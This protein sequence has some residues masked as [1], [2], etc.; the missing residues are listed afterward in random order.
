MVDLK[1]EN[2]EGIIQ[3][4][5]SVEMYKANDVYEEI[6]EMYLT[7]KNIICYYEKSN[8]LFA[9]SEE[10]IEKIPLQSIRIVNDK[11][12]ISKVDN[13][14]YGLGLQI[15]LQNGERAHFVFDKKKELQIWYDAILE[16]ITGKKNEG[17]NL[18]DNSKEKKN[19]IVNSFLGVVGTVKDIAKDQ[20]DEVKDQIDFVKDI[21]VDDESN[22]FS[23][24]NNKKRQREKEIDNENK[25]IDNNPNE[26]IEEKN[27]KE[28]SMY[29]SNCGKEINSNS[30]FCNCCGASVNIKENALEEKKEEIR[31]EVE[32]EELSERKI[33]YDGKIHKCPN[34]GDV[35]R[36]FDIVCP[37]CGFEL[38]G[39]EVSKTLQ[40]FIE[41]VNECEQTISNSPKISNGGWS[42]WSSGKKFGFIILNLIFAF[43]PLFIYFLL[44]FIKIKTKPNL[45]KEEQQ[46]ES[47]IENFPFPNDRESIIDALIFAKEKMDFISKEEMNRKNAYWFRLWSS[48]AEQLKHK[49]D[50]LF[51]NDKIVNESYD[52]ILNKNAEV[53][54]KLKIKALIGLILLIVAIVFL[55]MRS[56][57]FERMDIVDTTNYNATI[58]WQDSVLF[59][60]LP[61]PD[62]KNG[63]IISESSGQ[64][65]VEV[66]KVTKEDFEKYSKKCR[67]AGF[68]IDVTK[69]DTVFYSKDTDGF[70]LSIFYENKEQKMKIYIDSYNVNESV[71]KKLQEEKSKQDNSINSSK[72]ET[73]ESSKLDNFTK[74]Y[75]KAKFEKFN[76][77]ASENG[78][79]GTKIYINCVI[80]ETEILEADSTKSILGH[81]TDEDG[82][83]WLVN[84]HFI[85][86]V[87]E[88]YFDKYIGKN[89]V[90]KA[91]YDGFSGTRKMPYIILEEFLVN[92]TGEIVYGVQKV[93]SE[94]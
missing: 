83:K 90:L 10:I 84:L 31:N 57:L 68:N 21:F 36:A 19:T 69:N 37:S 45:S 28:K 41:K 76:S 26:K 59:N 32:M 35:V 3:Q 16:I 29:C 13:D 60:R 11:L 43:I 56:N 18:N 17:N 93:V 92:E 24:N 53:N 77:F 91:V 65:Q 9:K 54:K 81:I 50:L 64:L 94:Y 62:N 55:G 48:K 34:C 51:P 75:E 39:K 14:E 5:N 85:P 25:T 58:E 1:L 22:E 38:S 12:Q 89:I 15:L 79:G 7:N 87:S 49:A 86:A 73:Q 74:G 70:G 44:P 23:S 40:R 33:V 42:S 78:L 88:T 67:D 52:K 66:Y 2:D 61:H 46:L 8:G 82:N 6:Y 20:I 27:E 4:A 80:D 47:L 30:K 72:K 63:T 71:L